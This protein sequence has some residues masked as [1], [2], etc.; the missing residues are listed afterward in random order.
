M[1]ALDLHEDKPHPCPRTG[2]CCGRCKLAIAGNAAHVHH[3]ADHHH[4]GD[5]HG[6]ASESGLAV[7]SPRDTLVPCT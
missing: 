1:P 3:A 4:A 6:N 5:G 2:K 7:P